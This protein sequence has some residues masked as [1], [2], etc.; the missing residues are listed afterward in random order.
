MT[1]GTLLDNIRNNHLESFA[2]KLDSLDDEGL[3]FDPEVALVDD[4]GAL[5]L[6]GAL[7]LP[8]RVD[9][10]VED[11]ETG[12]FEELDIPSDKLYAF[13]PITV[14]WT[15]HMRV[16]FSPFRWEAC[17]V[18]A[19]GI[20]SGHNL[21]DLKQWYLNWFDVEDNELP[22]DEDGECDGFHEVVHSL[23]D[24]VMEESMLSFEVDLGSA[25]IEAFDG[26]L[27]ALSAMG[28]RQVKLTLSE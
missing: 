14:D 18:T 9:V 13:P 21:D 27:D 5:T 19:E 24:P 28:A 12:V 17:R 23:S 7:A 26:L 1:I 11:P 8:R 4:S 25:P 16:V 6:D 3:S 10:E 20:L 22:E 15:A 2:E